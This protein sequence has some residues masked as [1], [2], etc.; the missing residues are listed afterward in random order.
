MSVSVFFSNKNI[1]IVVGSSKGKHIYI[2]KLIDAPM[3]ENAILNGVV[4]GDS[5]E[6]IT[7][8]LKE[9]WT[10]NKLKGEVDL[11]INSPQL[12]SN[13][14]DMPVINKINKATEYLDKQASDEFGRFETP[15]KGWYLIGTDT[16]NKKDKKQLVVTEVAERKFLES[17]IKIFADAGITLASVHDG[18]NLATQMLS[19]CING[20]TAIYM[21]RDAQMLVTILYENGKYYYN[22]LKR[23]FQQPGTEEFAQEIRS[24]ISGIKQFATSKHLTSAI[25]DVYFAGMDPDEIGML[26]NYLKEAE[27]DISVHGTVAPSHIHFKKWNDKLSSYIYPISGLIIPKTGFTVLKAIKQTEKGYAQKKAVAKK[28]VP[29]IILAAFLLVITLFMLIVRIN[30]AS[31]LKELEEY[32]SKPAVMQSAMEYDAAIREASSIGEE[33]AGLDTLRA[34]LDSYPIP[35]SSI[36]NSISAVA[37]KYEVNIEFGSYDAGSGVFSTTASS[38]IVENINKFIAELLYMDIFE[39]VNYTGYSWNESDGT[40]SI[41]VICT[42]SGQSEKEGN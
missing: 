42:L 31:R 14:V 22:T 33:Q 35:D 24:N 17:Y 2:D 18:V 3:P 4:I 16:T 41:K 36:N 29:A 1:Q 7:A 6:A 34:Y 10:A 30:T 19:T 11:I 40:W 23:L 25:T 5:G 26:Q 8:K 9:I 15:I 39:N 27:P 28:S 21:I 32:N 12:I 37:N 20:A 38:P 13:R